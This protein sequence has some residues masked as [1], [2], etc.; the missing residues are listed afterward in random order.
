MVF[1]M[2]TTLVIDDGVMRR[3]KAEAARRGTTISNL[4][5]A[6]LRA[7]L[8]GHPAGAAELPPL[9][10]FDLGVASVDVADRDALSHTMEGL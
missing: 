9:P 6:A 1:H 8:D 5:E 7:L 2:K 4:V 10:S 3:L